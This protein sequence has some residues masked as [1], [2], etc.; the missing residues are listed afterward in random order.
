[1]MVPSGIAITDLS[2]KWG[3]VSVQNTDGSL[4]REYVISGERVAEVAAGGLTPP[5]CTPEEW[6]S[7]RVYVSGRPCNPG[8]AVVNPDGTMMVNY[9][10]CVEGQRVH[11]KLMQCFPSDYAIVGT[12]VFLSSA[13]REKIDAPFYEVKV[14]SVEV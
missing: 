2:A 9:G 12:T 4:C 14:H 8:Q 6:A 5:G 13:L 11:V 7:G 1:M 3:L 10:V